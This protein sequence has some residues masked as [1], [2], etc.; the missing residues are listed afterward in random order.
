MGR[1]V[2][3]AYKLSRL[4]IDKFAVVSSDAVSANC[5]AVQKMDKIPVRVTEPVANSINRP[6]LERRHAQQR[7]SRRSIQRHG[8][9]FAIVTAASRASDVTSCSRH[10]TACPINRWDRKSVDR[11]QREDDLAG[12][13]EDAIKGNRRRER[14]GRRPTL[15]PPK[16]TNLVSAGWPFYNRH[17]DGLSPARKPFGFAVRSAVFYSRAHRC[18]RTHSHR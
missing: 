1:V 7:R 4:F 18:T 10:A 14:R 5:L 8:A 3:V 12:G 15:P 16:H 17:P 2:V 13:R 6:H 11:R 9:R